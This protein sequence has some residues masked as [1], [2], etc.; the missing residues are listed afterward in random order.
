MIDKITID[1]ILDAANIV[2]VVSEFVT[3][4][5]RGVNYVGLCP[6]HDDRTPSFYV[7]PAKNI[8]KCFACGEGG[9]SVHFL[10]KHEQLT[11][12]DALRFLA[13]KYNIE[14]NER[15]LT[16]EEVKV[17]NDR[18][19]MLI[20][21][22]WAQKHFETLLHEHEEGRAV[23]LSYFLERGFREDIIRKFGLGY[24]L[25]QWD[26]LFQSAQKSGY[27]QTYLEKTG[28]V[29]AHESGKV[30]DRFRGRVIFP[31]YS[32]SGKVVAFGGRILK[33]SDRAAKYVNSPESEIYHKSNELYGIYFARQQIVKQSKCFL[34]E[35]YTDVLS[36]HQA[37]LENVVASSGTSLTTGQI[38]LIR[39]FTE[40]VTVIY[41][42]DS[43][44]INA[45]L[46][47]IDLL[48]EE[49]M[50]VKVVLLPNGED[51]D[52]FAKSHSSSEFLD[53]IKEREVD[54]INFKVNLLLGE[55]GDDPIK[56][57]RIVTDV[58]QTIA[59]IPNNIVRTE[60]VK[61]CASMLNVQEQLL[62]LEIRKLVQKRE[63]D[64]LQKKKQDE[65]RQ[66]ENGGA[67]SP[68]SSALPTRGEQMAIEEMRRKISPFF[69]YEEVLMRYVVRY[70]E[71]VVFKFND[72]KTEAEYTS[73]VAEFIQNELNRDDLHF[74]TPIYQQM[75]DEVVSQSRKEG[76]SASRYLLAHTDSEVSRTAAD[77]LSEKYQLS[78]VHSRFKEIETEEQNLNALLIHG[79]YT[80]KDAFIRF[81]IK[82]VQG[83][84]K[85][86]Q[87]QKN[88]DLLIELMTQLSKLND[89]KSVLSKQL[90]E[91]IILKM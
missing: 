4:K 10:M 13:K 64:S 16:E 71:R 24:S 48:L 3:L 38:R 87:K 55:A 6:F 69:S 31:V 75:L 19:S 37:G 12:P 8:C 30:S 34:V 40:N 7:S 62:A 74:F 44:G 82:E 33:K 84:I 23:G 81:R 88:T 76:F 79:I 43:A 2:D 65:E 52:S 50:N 18:E 90:G 22:S 27:Q 21:N 46:R 42:G 9:T 59:I 70:G 28:L 80:F 47:G 56:R 57:A 73:N 54:F 63:A 14:L 49:G 1:R 32:L 83:K 35:G 29:I 5:R 86:A 36:M 68:D 45:A 26:E 85:E 66:A 77:M 61:E 67:A 91:R 53:Y 11:Y 78:K 51:P 72:E 41:D 15:E 89:I 25:D 58:V 60:Y 20:V 17:Q 39:R